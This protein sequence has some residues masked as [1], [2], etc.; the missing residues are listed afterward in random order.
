[1]QSD[2]PTL[3]QAM[4]LHFLSDPDIDGEDS[5]Q[6]FEQGA[7]LVTEGR[8][9]SSG[10]C[11]KVHQEA[12]K[13]FGP[14]GYHVVD[15]KDCL[16]IPGMIDTHIHYP[17]VEVIASYG[18]QLLDWLNNYTF[19]AE[20]R[21]A[22]KKHASEIANFFLDELLR[23]GTTTAL[24]FGT[25]HKESVEAFFEASARRNTR[26]IC[27]KV[28]M[29]RNAPDY[30][31]DNAESSYTDSRNLIETWHGRGRQLYAVTP[32]FAITSTEEQLARAQQLCRE[33]PDVY[34]QTHIAEDK[35]EIA[36]VRTLFPDAVDYTDVYDRFN[37][38]SSRSIFAHG[39]F[40]SA[41]ERQRFQET[42][43]S[44][45]FC[46][47]SNLF[48]GSGLLDL[49]TLIK[50]G[51]PCSI[52]T[53][54]GGG[55]SFSMLRTLHEAYKVTRLHGKRLSPFM[56]FYLATLGGAR[57]LRIDDRIG[58]FRAGNEAD[59]A[60]LDFK[61]TPL[62]ALKQACCTNLAEK[63][64]TM[65]ILGDDRAVKATYVAG[66]LLHDRDKSK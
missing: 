5:Y 13:Q 47:S 18:E 11:D 3:Y 1:M 39:I 52:G 57:T 56:S 30:L 25:V 49:L 29:D 59:F 40:L 9:L 28:M 31:C 15:Y 21:F 61:C 22:D 41:R 65:I 60:V 53:D 44:V 42:G 66:K 37:L 20:G 55:T 64:F 27:G 24:V 2:T 19:P 58:S 54:V 10:P 35:D 6:F 38:L 46:P 16:I 48:I 8:I 7:I 45:S 50:E 12:R 32:R 14:T 26:M 4:I 23:C 62:M 63:L 51:V 17:Q 43:A 36:F 33:Y 34:L